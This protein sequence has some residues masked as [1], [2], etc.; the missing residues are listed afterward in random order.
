MW[1]YSIATQALFSVMDERGHDKEAVQYS[2]E[3]IPT[4]VQIP[5]LPNWKL[6][7]ESQFP[8][9]WKEEMTHMQCLT[10]GRCFIFVIET[11]VEYKTE[12]TLM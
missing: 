7:S 11:N 6:S 8:H 4:L 12:W 2:G 3:I 10:Q 9:L 5:A 1:V